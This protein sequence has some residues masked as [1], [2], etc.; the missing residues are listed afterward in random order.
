MQ[1]GKKRARP[2][3]A[4][5]ATQLN[6][7]LAKRLEV[8]RALAMDAY[9]YFGDALVGDIEYL[10]ATAE[11]L[12]DCD[13]EF[14][15]SIAPAD[16]PTKHR[17]LTLR[18]TLRQSYKTAFKRH[19]EI[20]DAIRPDSP[21]AARL[22]MRSSWIVV[23]RF[24]IQLQQ[25]EDVFGY[26]RSVTDWPHHLVLRAMDFAYVK[27]V[28]ET[29]C[30]L[31]I[32]D[33]PIGAYSLHLLMTSASLLVEALDKYGWT[34]SAGDYLQT[35]YLRYCLFLHK[36]ALYAGDPSDFGEWEAIAPL[37]SEPMLAPAVVRTAFL[38]V[39]ERL[40]F[41]HMWHSHAV[42]E[43][44]LASRVTLRRPAILPEARQALAQWRARVALPALVTLFQDMM[45]HE[46]LSSTVAKNFSSLYPGRLLWPGQ[47]DQMLFEYPREAQDKSPDNTLFRLRIGDYKALQ[48][49]EKEDTMNKSVHFYIRQEQALATT[50]ATLG[51]V[52]ETDWSEQFVV[53]RRRGFDVQELVD[54]E[55]VILLLFEIAFELR[56]TEVTRVY[57]QYLFVRHAHVDDRSRIGPTSRPC[58][59]RSELAQLR[60]QVQWP[61]FIAVWN[62]YCVAAPAGVADDLV[63]TTPHLVDALGL[64]LALAT[65]LPTSGS[66][67]LRNKFFS[68][69][70]AAL[71]MPL[72]LVQFTR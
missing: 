64:W 7:T 52:T 34:E 62:N 40:F 33:L 19:V 44:W 9:T 56:T 1:G 13:P 36:P 61:L 30:A 43:L 58:Y 29:H 17:L 22:F 15:P 57:G 42:R 18:D 67:L 25:V 69:H 16:D 28:T 10:D 37:P 11:T 66:F 3:K 8:K 51:E 38:D 12:D 14:N 4:P 24:A 54:P 32:S 65:K 68:A 26:N 50:A 71:R 53:P 21:D 39:G 41:H 20:R 35:L 27:R 59:S 5:Y 31:S 72:E 49:M 55:R 46:A 60:A 45:S 70:W 47:Q 63:Y 6:M 2:T 48:R 23:C